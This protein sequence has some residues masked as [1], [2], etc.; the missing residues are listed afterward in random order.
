MAKTKDIKANS[1]EKVRSPWRI[2]W[3]RLKRHKLAMI[4]AYILIVMYLSVIFAGFLSPYHM[5]TTQRNN[6]L[7]PPSKIYWKDENGKLSRPYVYAM[8]M[9]DP[10]T[11]EYQEIRDKKF[12]V[13]LF[14][15]SDD[16][17]NTWDLLGIKSNIHL[18]GARADDGEEGLIFIMGSDDYGRDYFTRVLYGGRASLFV[19]WAGILITLTIGMLFGGI[20]G[21]YGGWI[22]NIMMRVAEIIMSIPSFY[23]L[24]ALAAVL[25]R[26]ISSTMRYFMI[27][28][29]LS[30]I[31]WAGMARIIRG[32][33]L[34][35]RTREY[36]QAARAIGSSDMRII[37]KHIL[38]NT[39][40]FVIVSATLS[41]PGY[42][43]GESGLSFLGLGIQEPDASWGNM[44]SSAMN[45]QTLAKSPW[46]L[47]AGVFIFAA[48]LCY[49]L[50]GDGLRDAFDPRSKL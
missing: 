17:R 44:L 4:S 41:I 18:Y 46:N 28:S 2:A 11:Q 9:S 50:F 49:N 10:M 8:K 38:P 33:V 19:G 24:L 30:F 22:D 47:L 34:S 45:L 23:L 36:V 14:T 31:S 35:I 29:I 15:R 7:Q 43:L 1:G 27:V 5:H 40:S 26:D 6:Y 48:V 21:Y 3:M 13:R 39:L 12:Y 16:P 20:S 37:T 42:I 32:M 25:P